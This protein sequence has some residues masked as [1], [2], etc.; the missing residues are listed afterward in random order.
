MTN[1][2]VLQMLSEQ[3]KALL[4]R[5]EPQEQANLLEEINTIINSY[6]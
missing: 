3:L 1:Q 6:D 5:L 2:E 4:E